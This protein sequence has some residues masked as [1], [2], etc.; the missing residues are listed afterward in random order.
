MF[1]AIK[2]VIKSGWQSFKRNSGLSMATVFI[3]VMVISL[4]SALF[5]LKGTA[6]FLIADLQEKVDISVYFK[7]DS[8]EEDIIKIKD[9]VAK[10][11]EVK[12]VD[13]VSK[14]DSLNQFTE[15]H[16]NDQVLMESLK[17]LGLNPFL[18][19][20][21]IQAWQASQYTAVSDFL[22]NTAFKNLIEKVDYRERKPV[23][24]KLTTLTGNINKS[25]IIFSIVLGVIAVL[26][27]FNTIRL[28]IYNLREEISIMRL[29]GAS[30][31]FIRGPFIIQGALSG[32][33]SALISALIIGSSSY[34]LSSKIEIVIP[35]FNLFAYFAS[36]FFIILGVQVATGV[37]LGILSSVIAVRKNLEV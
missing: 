10:I 19:S 34:F 37:I 30:N 17:E 28:A 13:Y 8:P 24:E 36:N 5:L 33:I 14:E 35:G 26:V 11:P 22:D 21:N 27:A 12:S 7:E 15:R 1:I 20:L 25:G 23:I 32:L 3:M 16:K 6:E 4:T 2:R 31:W 18:P 29:V 9:E